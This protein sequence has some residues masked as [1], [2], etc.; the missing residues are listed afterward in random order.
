MASSKSSPRD[1]GNDLLP[2]RVFGSWFVLTRQTSEE[3]SNQGV[4]NIVSRFVGTHGLACERFAQQIPA[5]AQCRLTLLYTPSNHCY[6]TFKN[7]CSILYSGVYP[8]TTLQTN[9]ILQP[10]KHEVPNCSKN[11]IKIRIATR[12]K[13]RK[14]HDQILRN[15]D[16]M[17]RAFP[18]I[19]FFYGACVA[20]SFPHLRT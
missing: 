14:T 1:T 13:I 2:N 12:K 4:P 7:L 8:P 16:A 19:M 20:L 18:Q 9:Q 17:N 5:R 11:L 15:I 6:L 3:K 10:P